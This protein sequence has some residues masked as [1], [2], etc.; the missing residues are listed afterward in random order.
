MAGDAL[1][2]QGIH[3]QLE[4]HVLVRE[5]VQHRAARPADHLAERRVVRQVEPQHQAVDEKA[6]ER[7]QLR[8]RAAGEGR[9]HDDVRLARVTVQQRG[10]RGEQQHERRDLLAP[11]E[12]AQRLGELGRK[13]HGLEPATEALPGRPRV[14]Q[15]KVQR[16]GRGA[17]PV[18]PPREPGLLAG[19][20]ELRALPRR[21]V[22][23][24]ER[25]RWE[26]RALARAECLIARGQLLPQHIQRP[27]V[28]H[29]VV[30]HEQ[31]HVVGRGLPENGSADERARAQ[32]ERPARLGVHLRA[33]MLLALRGPGAACV[34][35]RDCHCRGH[36]HD[37]H[38]PTSA[39]LERGAQRF[40]ARDDLVQTPF[41]RVHVQRALETER[42]R[43]RVGGAVRRQLVQEP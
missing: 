4:R 24:L 37:R 5:Y 39:L 1:R 36:R 15:R 19:R 6:D 31:Q 42:L 30:Q 32:V 43:H 2:L 13:S 10:E 20:A 26:L 22:R 17:Q 34:D 16:R 7:L 9:A 33:Q 14:V 12:H 23:V 41:Q 29:D 28:A 18:P 38:R 8:P 40:V 25:Q 27:L 11:C 3:E 21:I 35:A